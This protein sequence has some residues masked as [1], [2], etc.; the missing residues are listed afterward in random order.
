VSEPIQRRGAWWQQQPDGTWLRWNADA[1][2]WEPQTA[3]P[4]PPAA[5]TA[6]APT[7][8]TSQTGGALPMR[9]SF[10]DSF[11]DRRVLFG[12]IGVAVVAVILLVAFAFA[13][14]GDEP[15]VPASADT[16]GVAAPG[17]DTAKREF[18]AAADA[19]CAKALRRQAKL[20]LPLDVAELTA[21][22][23]QSKEIAGRLLGDIRK[24]RPPRTDRV[25]LRR[26]FALAE[27]SVGLVDEIVAAA[28]RNDAA[29]VQSIVRKAQMIETRSTV[30]ALKYGFNDCSKSV[31][32]L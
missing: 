27:R 17:T 20:R 16:A 13:G 4:P 1:A 14:G 21:Y 10:V 26:M 29:A 2:A 28:Q 7:R 15:T 3:P 12:A 18:I 31:D 30:L 9:P 22:A 32:D 19:L 11:Q 25:L 8:A 5:P 6:M 24:L 23:T